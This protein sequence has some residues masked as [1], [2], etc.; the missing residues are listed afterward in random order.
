LFRGLTPTLIGILPYSGMS[1]A[2]FETVKARLLNNSGRTK[3]SSAESMSTG[4]LSGFLAQLATYPLDMC[5]HPPPP[6]VARRTNGHRPPRRSVRRRMQT[7]GFVGG[8]SEPGSPHKYR[9]VGQTFSLIWMEE[10]P[11]ALFKAVEMNAVKGPLAV[12]VSFTTFHWLNSKLSGEA[13]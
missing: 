13:D 6:A 12:G 11:R 7:E 1:F 10:G 8:D 3:L 9:R 2:C 4:A 5:V